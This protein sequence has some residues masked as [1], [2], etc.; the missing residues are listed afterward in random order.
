MIERIRKALFAHRAGTMQTRTPRQTRIVKLAGV[1]IY[2]VEVWKP[3][4]WWQ[5]PSWVPMT[6]LD[7]ECREVPWEGT[8]YLRASHV[9][10]SFL[11]EANEVIAR[12]D[13]A[14]V[15]VGE[16]DGTWDK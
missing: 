6:R 11:R 2:R 9:R 14:W 15:E 7:D 13:S 8:S 4:H 12:A 16:W 3:R 10:D 5:S 1:D